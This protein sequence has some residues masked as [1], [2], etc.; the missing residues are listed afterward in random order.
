MF[1]WKIWTQIVLLSVCVHPGR[2]IIYLCLSVQAE[3]IVF[4]HTHPSR[5]K[6]FSYHSVF[7]VQI[8]GIFQNFINSVKCTKFQPKISKSVEVGIPLGC[9]SGEK[10]FLNP[11]GFR[12]F[13]ECFSNHYAKDFVGCGKFDRK[14]TSNLIVFFFNL[15]LTIKLLISL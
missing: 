3:L 5:V 1:F 2:L 9:T 15:H 12:K 10:C 14:F 11:I 4:L 8:R 13:F 7:F 6:I